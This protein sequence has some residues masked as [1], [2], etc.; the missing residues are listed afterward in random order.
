[1]IAQPARWYHLAWASLD[2]EIGLALAANA[3]N[4]ARTDAAFEEALQASLRLLAG[5]L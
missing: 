5:Q 4:G 3:P 2:R 1:V